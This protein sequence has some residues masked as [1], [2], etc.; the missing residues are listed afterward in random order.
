MEKSL[1]RL[2]YALVIS[3]MSFA[4]VAP[5]WDRT[6]FRSIRFIHI[7][8]HKSPL[9][10]IASDWEWRDRT[11]LWLTLM[12]G[13]AIFLHHKFHSL[14]FSVCINSLTLKLFLLWDVSR[15]NNW[16]FFLL[17]RF[18]RIIRGEQ[19]RSKNIFFSS[20]IN[21]SNIYIYSTACQ[22]VLEQ[23]PFTTLETFFEIV[24]LE[25][26]AL[27]CIFIFIPC[28]TIAFEDAR[29]CVVVKTT[30]FWH[31]QNVSGVE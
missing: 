5:P 6:K 28:V 15:A 14:I 23:L 10:I 8:L 2:F 18:C 7:E 21:L 17:L 4:S 12:N 30:F 24:R 22:I 3:E 20:F 19:T 26:A 1:K 9:H 16:N 11:E 25:I 31:H 13:L 29:N 27:S